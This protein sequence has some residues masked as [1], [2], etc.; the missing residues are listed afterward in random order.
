MGF[1]SDIN[2]CMST[3]KDDAEMPT[4]RCE[5]RSEPF[6]M[7]ATI[8]LEHSLLRVLLVGSR[9]EDF[10]LIREIPDRNHRAL[11]TELDH[12]R[13][14]EEAETMLQRRDYGLLLFEYDILDAAA[15]NASLRVSA[16]ARPHTVHHADGE[17][18]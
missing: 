18:R 7:E 2:G 6:F 16:Y 1:L 4:F 8:Q 3:H 12:A 15:T 13:S 10:F 14:V 5:N 9:E 11:P 17:R